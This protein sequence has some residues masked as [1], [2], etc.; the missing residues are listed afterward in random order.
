MHPILLPKNYKYQIFQV[1]VR[2]GRKIKYLKLQKYNTTANKSKSDTYGYIGTEGIF[3]MQ[4]T[5]GYLQ[6]INLLKVLFLPSEQNFG[7][8]IRTQ[9]NYVRTPSMQNCVRTP[10]TKLCKKTRHSV[11]HFQ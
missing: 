3:E 10:S 7:F 1:F 5:Y 4:P 6:I 11:T 8:R 9:Q 2:E